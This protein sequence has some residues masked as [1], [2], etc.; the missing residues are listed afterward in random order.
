M[1]G[2]PTDIPMGFDDYVG[3]APAIAALK[4][5]VE[6]VKRGM[7]LPHIGCFGP[8][9][10]GKTTMASIVAKE[11]ER[12]LVYVNSVAV[13]RPTLLRGLI[14]HPVNMAKGAVVVL[15]E[16]HRLP[17]SIQDNMLS[18]LESPAILVTEEKGEII[19]D[20]LPD[21]ISFFLCTTHQ[22]LI[23]DALL[24]R[25][26]IV[27][28]HENT[29]EEKQEIALRYLVRV[30]KMTKDQIDLDAIIDIGRRSRSGRN[31]LRTCDNVVRSIKPGE[32]ITPQIVNE[33]YTR[34]GIDVNGL[35]KRDRD[36]LTYVSSKGCV[37]LETLE[38]VLNTPKKDIK[39]KVEPFL[40]RRNFISRHATGRIITERGRA[41][42]RYERVPV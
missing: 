19:R 11:S 36:L 16:C 5:F 42:L 28:V 30:Y 27:E 40:L 6:A 41:A 14:T 12:E 39:D 17:P 15:D 23:R 20:K 4:L 33:V 32:K 31:V 18:A 10:N 1:N 7:K 38:A 26:E 24:S 37:G 3:N 8:P 2:L 9:G 13:K 34:L 35:T 21:N 29:T 25:L 22:G